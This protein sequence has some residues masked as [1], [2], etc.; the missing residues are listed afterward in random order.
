[1]MDQSSANSGWS[2]RLIWA[3]LHVIIFI[4]RKAVVSSGIRIFGETWNDRYM[5]TVAVIHFSPHCS[6]RM[7]LVML[8]ERIDVILRDSDKEPSWKKLK[9]SRNASEWILLFFPPQ[10]R[11]VILI[12]SATW[13][14]STLTTY[15]IPAVPSRRSVANSTFNGLIQALVRGILTRNP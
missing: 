4:A 5:V 13:C 6:N 1:M 9:I 2:D 3:M 11:M 14:P 7:Y 12:Y 15:H 8:Y 10:M